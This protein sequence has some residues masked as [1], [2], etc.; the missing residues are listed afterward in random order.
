MSHLAIFMVNMMI[1]PWGFG[2]IPTKAMS[3]LVESVAGWW[4]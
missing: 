3:H 4:F 1:N 2:D